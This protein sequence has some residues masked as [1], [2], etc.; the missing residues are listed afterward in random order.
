MSLSR[1]V[2][3]RRIKGVR[4]TGKVTHAM[5]MVA[6]AR[7]RRVEV[8]ALEARPYAARLNVLIGEVVSQ[9]STL[10]EHPLLRRELDEDPALL[11]HFTP[12][13]G[14][15]GGLNTRLSQSL[16]GFLVGRPSRAG[17]VTIGKKGREFALRASL[18]L[19]AEFPGFGDAPGVADLRPL[20]LL[21]IDMF[22]RGEFNSVYLSYPRF[23]GVMAQ[24]PVIEQL[25][26]A[27]TPE[28]DKH[29]SRDYLCEPD[30]SEV[31]DALM[32]RYVESSVYHAYLECV[33]SEYSA[34]MVAMHNATDSARELVEEMTMELNKSRQAAITAE[35]C[36]VAAGTE[37]LTGGRRG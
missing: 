9:S 20:C 35:I 15:C 23:E 26:P 32:M 28:V 6:S 36:D 33:A 13:K 18:N 8:R 22:S 11:L 3:V 12:D 19:V 30:A 27:Q 10:R 5:E 31:L 24:R 7:M 34:R 37:A 2:L 29:S 17:V 21:A 1:Q 25:L 16:G 14:L 4:E